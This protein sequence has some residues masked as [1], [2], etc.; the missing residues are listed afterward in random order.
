MK[1]TA[2]SLGEVIGAPL[3]AAI[4]SVDISVKSPFAQMVFNIIGGSEL[5]YGRSVDLLLASFLVLP[6]V[7][8]TLIRFD[9]GFKSLCQA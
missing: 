9:G 7:S 4:Q 3:T 2:N 1:K 8:G 6:F 5:F